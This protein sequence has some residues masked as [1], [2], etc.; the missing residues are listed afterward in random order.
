MSEPSPPRGRG[1]HA[2]DGSALQ[3]YLH[4]PPGPTVDIIDAALGR[5]CH[6]LELGCGPGRITRGLVDR[7]HTVTAVDE[8]SQMLAHVTGA[9]TVCADA[10]TLRLQ[11]RFD[12]IVAASHLVNDPDD[13]RRHTLFRTCARHLAPGGTLVMERYAPDWTPANGPLGRR[14]DFDLFLEGAGRDGRD[15]RFTVIYVRGEERWTHPMIGRLLD[16]DDLAGE[17]ARVGLVPG[18]VLT[19]DRRW[20]TAVMPEAA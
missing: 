15:V 13:G 5:P 9:E 1:H 11:R 8:S 17:L 18:P 12:A 4:L 19:E 16:D 3:V 10:V 2:P 7:G 20:V 6:I 14:G